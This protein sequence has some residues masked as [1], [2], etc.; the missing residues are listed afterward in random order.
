MKNGSHVDIVLGTGYQAPR[1]IR[2][3]YG[4]RGTP[5]WMEG[6]PLPKSLRSS[7][8]ATT[9]DGLNTGPKVS[10]PSFSTP[11]LNHNYHTR[12]ADCSNGRGIYGRIT[13]EAV[14]HSK[15]DTGKSSS[16]RLGRNPLPP[17]RYISLSAPPHN[18]PHSLEF[19]WMSIMEET[20]SP[21]Q[22]RMSKPSPSIF[23]LPREIRNLIY[24]YACGDSWYELYHA[25]YHESRPGPPKDVFRGASDDYRIQEIPASYVKNKNIFI[26][27][28][29][30]RR[31]RGRYYV[32]H[33]GRVALLYV[34]KQT[35]AEIFPAF[36][37][38]STFHVTC[39]HSADRLAMLL[40]KGWRRYIKQISGEFRT[41]DVIEPSVF[42][43]LRRVEFGSLRTKQ[44]RH[45]VHC[46]LE[47]LAKIS[48]QELMDA[49][50][51][52]RG[53]D[54]SP[55]IELIINTYCR[56]EEGPD[57]PE[58]P[59]DDEDLVRAAHSKPHWA[60]Y[61]SLSVQ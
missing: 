52:S 11:L 23:N 4:D 6:F 60:Y 16:R 61:V 19:K 3:G 1:P 41:L 8:Q 53:L 58:D 20:P 31:S 18:Y 26:D 2:I 44:R 33:N 56:V 37:G 54:L 13:S 22:P 14:T 10:K 12:G 38:V 21:D 43:S 24:L 9:Q 59:S 45:F 5:S 15:P 39:V 57:A 49:A 55:R 28:R 25:D 35:R 36:V 51:K 7:N 50:L 32:R 46:T 48:D 17:A 30:D 42:P 34:C 29:V 40:P 27:G 47:E